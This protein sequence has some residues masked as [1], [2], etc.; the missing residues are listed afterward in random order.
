MGAGAEAAAP[1][2]PDPELPA[3]ERQSAFV[4]FFQKGGNFMWPL[5]LCAL[6]G[7]AVTLER[8]F[9]M[10]RAHTDTRKLM[11]AVVASLRNG[12]GVGE[13]KEICMNTRG[14][15]AAI[16]HAGL[17]K[18]ERGPAAVEKAIETSGAIEMSFLQRGLVILS[19]V[20]NISPLVGFLGTV[21]GMIN[22]FEAIAAAEQVSAKVVAS[23]IS[24]ALITTMTGLVIAIPAQAM[25]NFF[26]T[27]ID[28][29][30]TE[31]E[32]SAVELLDTLTD[33]EVGQ[34]S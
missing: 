23:G 27:R 1:A 33:L 4:E 31:M 19:S 25:F 16:L 26:I 32:E 29:F 10:Q 21:S 22:A 3:R 18:V 34:R 5:L 20:A 6:L 7:L 24:E 30:V 15:I 8:L 9:T 11:T 2:L 13:A 17:T 12:R 14:P 28:R